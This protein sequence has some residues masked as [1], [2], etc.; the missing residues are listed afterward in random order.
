M[1]GVKNLLGHAGCLPEK[2]KSTGWLYTYMVFFATLLLKGKIICPSEH[3]FSTFRK[4]PLFPK[5]TLYKIP[6]AINIASF[7]NNEN[8][9]RKNVEKYT[10]INVGN[11][12]E[13]KDQISLV[14]IWKVVINKNNLAKLFIVGGGSK[15]EELKTFIRNQKLENNVFLLGPRKD[16]PQLLQKADIF[17]FTSKNIEGFGTVLIE[18][19]ATGMKIIAFNEPAAN[20]LLNSGQY[21]KLIHDRNIEIFASEILKSFDEPLNIEVN[22]KK[23]D[24]ANSFNIK[25]MVDSYI[26]LIHFK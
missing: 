9:Y 19:L 17:A 8:A 5:K 18:A 2:S 21:G 22:Q 3:I 14:K 7:I 20:E 4:I 13:A 12:E 16:I 1:T 15:E 25:N 23:I 26:N 11:L 24:Y 10:A 6:N